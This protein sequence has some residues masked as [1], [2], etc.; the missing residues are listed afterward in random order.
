MFEAE[1]A[2]VAGLRTT[3]LNSDFAEDSEDPA[4]METTELLETLARGEDS[5]HQFTRDVTNAT[6]LASE[7]AAFANSGGGQIFIGIADDGTVK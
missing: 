3:F 1:R 7:M 6:S 4:R 2:G 5:R